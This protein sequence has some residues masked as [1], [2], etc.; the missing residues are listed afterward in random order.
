MKDIHR[1]L[2]SDGPLQL[3]VSIAVHVDQIAHSHETVGQAHGSRVAMCYREFISIV[4]IFLGKFDLIIKSENVFDGMNLSQT[5]QIGGRNGALRDGVF[6]IG[7]TVLAR[8]ALRNV[9]SVARVKGRPGVGR[10]ES[11]TG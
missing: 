8:Y 1:G 4:Q 2:D 7:N 6:N 9:H 3:V 11:I 5:E 10:G